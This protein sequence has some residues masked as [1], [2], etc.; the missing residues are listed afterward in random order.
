LLVFKTNALFNSHF[1]RGLISLLL[2]LLQA[3]LS[4]PP[5]LI[6]ELLHNEPI[7]LGMLMALKAQLA[8]IVVAAEHALIIEPLY[9]LH[10]APSAQRS[11]VG[12]ES[13]LPSL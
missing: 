6:G 11:F 5:R 1:L 7:V 2:I 4:P 3:N 12:L 8:K 13:S 10:S 9:I